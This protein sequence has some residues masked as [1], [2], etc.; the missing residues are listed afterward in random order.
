MQNV[1]QV[2]L[3]F[4]WLAVS[5][6]KYLMIDQHRFIEKNMMDNNGVQ[7]CE[8]ELPSGLKTNIHN[9]KGM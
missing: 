8:H 4:D 5:K 3:A 1:K 6:K 2:G 7:Y 9:Y